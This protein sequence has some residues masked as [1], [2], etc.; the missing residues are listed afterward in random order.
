MTETTLPCGC[1]V[2]AT[3]DGWPVCMLRPC[4]EYPADETGDV[5]AKTRMGA[6]QAKQDRATQNRRR[7]AKTAAAKGV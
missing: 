7:R 2:L 6:A 3:D 1:V 5:L 4:A